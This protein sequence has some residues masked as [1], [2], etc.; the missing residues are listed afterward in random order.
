MPK[1]VRKMKILNCSSKCDRGRGVIF[2]VS[3]KMIDDSQALNPGSLLFLTCIS[4]N[5][6]FE[7]NSWFPYKEHRIQ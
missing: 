6:K 5:L 3:L 2:F 7:Y 4:E 1:E